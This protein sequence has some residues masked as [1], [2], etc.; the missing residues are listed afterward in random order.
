V[1]DRE[2]REPRAESREQS[3]ETSSVAPEERLLSSLGSETWGRNPRSPTPVLIAPNV[4][5]APV[6][7]NFVYDIHALWALSTVY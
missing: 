1:D 3:E 4:P 2:N 6:T 5:S 7:L